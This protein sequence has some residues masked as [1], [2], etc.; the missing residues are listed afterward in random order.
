MTKYF[1]KQHEKLSV[2][3]QDILKF[4]KNFGKN[5]EKSEKKFDFF[6][7]LQYN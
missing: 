6:G 2:P 5:N 7:I 4:S 1:G 3:T